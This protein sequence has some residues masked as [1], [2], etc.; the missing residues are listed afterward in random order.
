MLLAIIGIILFSTNTP[1]QNV[2]EDGNYVGVLVYSPSCPHC[3]ALINYLNEKYP[4][5]PILRTTDASK[6][7]Q[8]LEEAGVAWQGGVPILAIKANSKVYVIS[9]FPSESQLKDG[10][11]FGADREKQLCAQWNGTAYE[12]NGRYLFC[13]LKDGTIIGNEHAVDWV[14]SKILKSPSGPAREG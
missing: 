10:Y 12:E 2:Q 6:I 4:E 7:K 3:H 8:Y 11:F 9:G 13:Q 1:K 5:V 14:M